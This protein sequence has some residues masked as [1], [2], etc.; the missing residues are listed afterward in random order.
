VPGYGLVDADYAQRLRAAA[1]YADAGPIYMLSLAKFRP[2]SG[3]RLGWD[4]GRDP[5]SRYIPIPLL[6]SAGAALCFMADVVAGPADW[7]RVGIIWYPTRR[8]FVEM[9]DRR[10]TRDWNSTKERRVSRMALLGL[11]PTGDLPAADGQR[12]L[13]EIWNGPEPALVADGKVASFDVEGTYIGDGR[14]WSGVR[15][16]A[17]EPGTALPLLTARFGH[18]ALLLEPVIER[19]R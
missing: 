4:S 7:D 3:Q 5:D 11:T 10:D 1:S 16:T 12:I 13:L 19:W 18:Q 6:T 14:Q 15:C 8:S 2:G 17:V 9:G